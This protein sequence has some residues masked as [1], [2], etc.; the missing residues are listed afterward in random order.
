MNPLR[1]IVLCI[2]LAAAA[3]PATAQYG[4]GLGWGFTGVG[5]GNWALYED[6]A[7]SIAAWYGLTE[8]QRTLLDSLATQ[9]RSQNADAV[10]RWE[11]MQR[12][13]QEL[14]A[15]DRPPTW[16]AISAVG[17]KYGHPGQELQTALFQLHLRS[18][19]LLAPGRQHFFGW[20]GFGG[21]GRGRGFAGG[22]F[23]TGYRG[24][25][26]GRGFNRWPGWV[27]PEN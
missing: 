26:G 1:S 4:R 10:A 19:A 5:L 22:R 8:E 17:E 24:A 3:G 11:Q 9:F 18:A 20:R 15:G 27:P 7:D 16:A 13:I 25:W 6:G 12:E 2:T 21:M 14:W 23:S